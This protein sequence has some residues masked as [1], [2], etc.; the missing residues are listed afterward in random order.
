VSPVPVSTGG[1]Y[2]AGRI[3]KLGKYATPFFENI[4]DCN[5]VVNTSTILGCWSVQVLPQ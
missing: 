3:E 4:S 1:R 5:R 2:E